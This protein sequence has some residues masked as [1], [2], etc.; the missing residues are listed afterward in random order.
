MRNSHL[1]NFMIHFKIL[2]KQGFQLNLKNISKKCI[3]VPW[4]LDVKNTHKEKAP[5][6]KLQRSQKSMNIGIW[7]VGTSYQLFIRGS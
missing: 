6:I 7:I 3:R 5:S 4:P 1:N 2:L